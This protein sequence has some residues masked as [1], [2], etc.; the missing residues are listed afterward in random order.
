MKIT[1]RGQ[2]TIPK[3]LRTRYGIT[4]ETEIEV[5]DKAGVITLTPKRDPKQFDAA[6]AKWLGS[7]RKRMKQ[8]GFESSD[9][10][11]EAI[12]GRKL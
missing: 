5:S 2:I 6:V 8:L 3:V 9:T 10:F 12:R 11:F 7:G 4:P 1:E